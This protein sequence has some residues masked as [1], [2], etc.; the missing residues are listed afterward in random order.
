MDNA[1]TTKPNEQ[2][3][4]VAEK[5]LFEKFYNPSAM[6][7]EGH[8]V[9][10]ELKKAR[11]ALLSYIGLETDFEL[12]F[13]KRLLSV[14]RSGEYYSH[15]F[16]TNLEVFQEISE[17]AESF[18]RFYGCR[19]HLSY[20]DIT[21]EI[22]PKNE[23]CF[24][25]CAFAIISLAFLTRTYSASREAQINVHLD[26]LGFYFDLTFDIAEQY[27]SQRLAE[28]APEL[29]NLTERA[30]DHMFDCFCAQREGR[31][32]ARAFLWLRTPNSADIK[33][34]K[35]KFIYDC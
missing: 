3:V 16:K 14:S 15:L 27:S 22:D 34:K 13:A 4:K 19:F 26:E 20:K 2:A 31:F 18:G 7:K 11:S 21:E 29:I 30:Y 17:I 6:Y 8:E 5:Y 24:E 33:E 25:S 9:Q 10:G 1:A 35:A 32:I 12:I 23:F 28:C